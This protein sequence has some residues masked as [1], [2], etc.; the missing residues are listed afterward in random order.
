MNFKFHKFRT[1]CTKFYQN[2]LAFVED[3]TKTFWC[4]FNRFTVYVCLFT[5][6]T[7]VSRVAKLLGAAD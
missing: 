3:R 1:M 4:V 6:S 5:R 2:R 7:R